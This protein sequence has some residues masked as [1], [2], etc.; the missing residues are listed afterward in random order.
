MKTFVKL[1]C[2]L[3][4]FLLPAC[5]KRVCV[6][7]DTFANTHAIPQGFATGSTFA[8]MWKHKDNQLFMQ[9]IANKISRM[10]E[11]AGCKIVDKNSAQH[12]LFFDFDVTTAKETKVV[13][14]YTPTRSH[15][16]IREMR[17]TKDFVHEKLD[18]VSGQQQDATSAYN[19][20]DVKPKTTTYEETTQTGSVEYT[21]QEQ[22]I[23]TK[24]LSMT[25]Y[26]AQSWNKNKNSMQVWHAVVTSCDDA[27]DKREAVD[28]LLKAAFKNFGSDS[29]KHIIEEIA[30]EE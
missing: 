4:L 25:V 27:A 6:T 26:D 29:K 8:V 14:L 21:Y 24:K 13:P 9:E 16:V 7:R 5:V 19:L 23:I 17:D 28:Y 18:H 10:L 1:C 30:G 2:I 3:S 15:K 22:A 11:K 12:Y 20:N